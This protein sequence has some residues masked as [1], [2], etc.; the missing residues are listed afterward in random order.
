MLEHMSRA[1]VQT[2][3]CTKKISEN[4]S[5]YRVY[6][7]RGLMREAYDGMFLAVVLCCLE[8]SVGNSSL[9]QSAKKTGLITYKHRCAWAQ[10]TDRQRKVRAS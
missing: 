9:T 2:P 1:V 4:K 3:Q 10:I 5:D 8:L 6:E 7:K